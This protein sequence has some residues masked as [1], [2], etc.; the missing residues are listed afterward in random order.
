MWIHAHTI[1]IG[2][3]SHP[4]V[5]YNFWRDSVYIP[6][7]FVFLFYNIYFRCSCVLMSDSDARG[8]WFLFIFYSVVSILFFLLTNFNWF[9]FLAYCKYTAN[10]GN[11]FCSIYVKFHCWVCLYV[12][13]I[14]DHNYS[15]LHFLHL[16]IISNYPVL[17]I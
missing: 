3:K 5:S 15:H 14:L 9:V 8:F 4:V 2:I 13:T 1:T 6:P 7:D 16:P 12:C 11:L 10:Y 17:V